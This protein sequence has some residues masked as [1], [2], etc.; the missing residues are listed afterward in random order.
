MRNMDSI[1]IEGINPKTLSRDE[2]RD[3]FK[4]SFLDI[5]YDDSGSIVEWNEDQK[6]IILSF[7]QTDEFLRLI[8]QGVVEMDLDLTNSDHLRQWITFTRIVRL[9]FSIIN[10]RSQDTYIEEFETVITDFVD[11]INEKNNDPLKDTSKSWLKR[12]TTAIEE[13]YS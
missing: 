3:V 13:E 6:Q 7:P 4:D 10:R 9:L 1:R 11:L 5:S 12:I 8:Q 2:F